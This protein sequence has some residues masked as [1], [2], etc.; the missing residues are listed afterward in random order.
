MEAEGR[1]EME[2]FKKTLNQITTELLDNYIKEFK[3]L[4][5]RPRHRCDSCDRVLLPD[6]TWWFCP[7][8]QKAYSLVD[9]VDNLGER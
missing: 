7:G 2:T 6:K 8:C 4:Q 3:W 5:N 9:L 1:L